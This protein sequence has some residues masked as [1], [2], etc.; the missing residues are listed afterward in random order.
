MTPTMRP[1][2][3]SRDRGLSARTNQ[4][5]T[6]MASFDV[7]GLIRSSSDLATSGNL[8]P[9]S[10]EEGQAMA[11]RSHAIAGVVRLVVSETLN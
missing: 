5:I 7:H 6:V 8:L 3:L 11:R 4:Q 1:S 2:N 9:S 10:A